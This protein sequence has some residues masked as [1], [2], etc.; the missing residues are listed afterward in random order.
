M[1]HTFLRKLNTWE[2]RLI[3]V[4]ECSIPTERHFT[5]CASL[6]ALGVQRHRTWTC[7]VRSER[8]CALS[9]RRSNM[10]R[11]TSSTMLLSARL[12]GAHGLVEINTRLRSDPVLQAA[13]GRTACADQSLVQRTL[14]AC[15]ATTV[16]QME[17][18][19]DVIYRQH[20]QGNRHDYRTSLQVLDVDMSGLPCGKK[21]AFARH[22]AIS[23]SSATGAGD[24]WG[25]C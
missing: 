19:M 22:P 24:S 16:G 3:I 25:A 1:V 15:T 4:I 6:A 21:A 7:L 23:P 14:D 2:R 11:V 5:A 10:H 20:S 13:F 18:A 9:R 12:S 17:Q 8:R